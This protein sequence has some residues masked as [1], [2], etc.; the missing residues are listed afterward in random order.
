MSDPYYFAKVEGW[1][2]MKEW[3]I[4]KSQGITFRDF[5]RENSMDYI[6]FS[7]YAKYMEQIP[8]DIYRYKYASKQLIES[9]KKMYRYLDTK[10]CSNPKCNCCPYIEDD[11]VIQDRVI[12]RT[13]S[14]KKELLEAVLHPNR[15]DRMLLSYGDAWVDTHFE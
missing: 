2:H 6:L 4:K 12:S 1:S 8:T 5:C 11:D 14:M 13:K 15:C 3:I 10:K 7:G 9:K